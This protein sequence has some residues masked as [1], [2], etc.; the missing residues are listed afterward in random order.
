[1]KLDEQVL[2]TIRNITNT[3]YTNPLSEDD[4]LDIIEELV[5]ELEHKEEELSDLQNDI[6]NNYELKRIDPYEEYGV[7]E[8]DFI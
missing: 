8:R 1:M 7:S 2:T 6:E 5:S 4:A 3:L